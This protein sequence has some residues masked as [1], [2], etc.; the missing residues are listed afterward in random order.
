MLFIKDEMEVSL[1]DRLN[2]F[3]YEEAGCCTVYLKKTEK[4][5]VGIVY[6]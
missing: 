4:L 2:E 6:M 1:Y 5:L 3:F